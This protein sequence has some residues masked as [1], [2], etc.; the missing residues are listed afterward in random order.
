MATPTEQVPAQEAYKTGIGPAP[1]RFAAGQLV[2]FDVDDID[3]RLGRWSHGHANL[4]ACLLY[5]SD[6]ADE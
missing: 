1:C 6:A 5:T 4:L 3:G 2:D